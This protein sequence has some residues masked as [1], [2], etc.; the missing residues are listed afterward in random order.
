[1]VWPDEYDDW[2]DLQ[3]D[4][5]ERLLNETE[6]ESVNDEGS[7]KNRVEDPE[8][9]LYWLKKSVEMTKEGRHEEAAAFRETAMSIIEKK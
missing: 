9:P 8:D 4:E 1:M 6:N 7:S 2:D 5:I 3:N